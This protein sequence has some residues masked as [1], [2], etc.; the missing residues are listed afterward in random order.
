MS[1]AMAK[2]ID[3]QLGRFVDVDLDRAGHVWGSSMRIRVSMEVS[4][5]LRVLKLRTTLG[6]EQLLSFTYERLPNFCYLCGC[7]GYLSKFC[8]LRFAEDFTDPGEATP[9]GPWMRAIFPTGRN[10]PLAL[11]RNMSIP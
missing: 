1:E 5:P 11:S 4:K 10:R 7:L 8:E 6:D 3:N 2:F 9:F